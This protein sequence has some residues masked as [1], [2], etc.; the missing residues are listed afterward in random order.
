MKAERINILLPTYKRVHSG[1]LPACVQSFVNRVSDI[2]N[3]VFTFFVNRNDQETIDYLTTTED[4]TCGFQII[5]ADYDKP[6]LGWFYNSLYERTQY[7][8]EETLV[9]LIG[10]DMVCHTQN[11]DR[12]IL[13]A[14]NGLD[15]MGIVHCRDGIQNGKIGVNLFTTRRWVRATGGR[16]ME[17]FPADFVDSI[18]TEVA[19]RTGREIY[20]DNVFI[21][22]RHSSLKPVEQWD[23]GFRAL[24]AEWAKYGSDVTQRVEACISRQIEVVEAAI[25]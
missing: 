25:K 21:E 16:F 14:I 1:M 8:D 22:H 19:R 2:Q 20:L 23:E 11:W 15:G 3:L 12:I 4:I 13:D 24:R 10:D 17:D 18:Y 7:Q 6:H 9:T 5:L